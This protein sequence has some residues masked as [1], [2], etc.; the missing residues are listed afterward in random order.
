MGPG[1]EVYPAGLTDLLVRLKRE[2]GPRA[3]IMTENGAAFDD[4][5]DGGSLIQDCQRVAYVRDH[6]HAV[7]EALAQGVPVRGYFLWS[8]MDN[9]EWNEGYSKRFGMVYVD[10]AT[11]RRIVKASGR[12]YADFVASQY[13]RQDWPPLFVTA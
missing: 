1:W 7:G 5:W 4:R 10:Y 11:Q 3:I 12:W 6:I 2:Y 9:F 13:A 8:L